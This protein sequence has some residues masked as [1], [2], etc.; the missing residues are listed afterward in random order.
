MLRDATE[1]L[2]PM[3]MVSHGAFLK[4]YRAK[5]P[6]KLSVIA[7]AWTTLRLESSE[8]TTYL[9]GLAGEQRT[10]CTELQQ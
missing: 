10:G 2:A 6:L 4:R 5:Q 9:V 3:L 8:V 7:D 1:M